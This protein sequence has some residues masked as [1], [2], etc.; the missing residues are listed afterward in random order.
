M[1]SFFVGPPRGAIFF[2]PRQG[3]RDFD[4][5]PDDAGKLF[6]RDRDLGFITIRRNFHSVF[7]IRWL[8]LTFRIKPRNKLFSFLKP[9]QNEQPECPGSIVHSI[10]TDEFER[11]IVEEDLDA[12]L[13]PQA[14]SG[15]SRTAEKSSKFILSSIF[16]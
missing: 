9:R 4:I 12:A 2:F 11:I 8:E 16:I 13:L 14:R 1:T 7:E 15:S 3:I 6:G 10:E 5:G